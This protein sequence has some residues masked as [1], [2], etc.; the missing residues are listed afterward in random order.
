MTRTTKLDKPEVA[1]IVELVRQ[2]MVGAGGALGGGKSVSA[3]VPFPTHSTPFSP[4]SI[5]F[6]Y[7][8][9]EMTAQMDIRLIL[10]DP[11]AQH[12]LCTQLLGVLLAEETPAARVLLFSGAGFL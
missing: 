8:A 6:C 11:F 5:H 2:T 10:R 3:H 12:F 1:E 4:F 7:Q 9:S